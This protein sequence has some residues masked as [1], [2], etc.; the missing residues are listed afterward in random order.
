VSRPGLKTNARAL[1]NC[2]SAWDA[3]STGIWR[4]ARNWWPS[5][6]RPCPTSFVRSTA[7][8]Y[9]R[10][11]RKKGKNVWPEVE[12]ALWDKHSEVG[13]WA[14]RLMIEDGYEK[15]DER[16]REV[17]ARGSSELRSYALAHVREM[18]DKGKAY[19]PLVRQLLKAEDPRVR[20]DAI[21]TCVVLMDSGQLDFLRQTYERDT[22]PVVR[23][24]CLRCITVIPEPPVEGIELFLKGLEQL[25]RKGCKQYFG[26]D[27]RQPL[28]I[29]EHAIK[30]WRAWYEANK[31]KLQWHP[32]LRKFLLP[33]QRPP[34]SGE[35]K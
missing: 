10:H 26:Y 13:R 19:L 27:A 30:K 1:S 32:D 2:A 12:K 11:Y 17:L 31:A 21:H 5:A 6:S 18:G 3:G 14:L 25:L 33:G 34:K 4:P 8:Y 28:P 29:R 7:V 15:A 22:D 35:A 16:L 23:E 9:L 24:A 20:Y